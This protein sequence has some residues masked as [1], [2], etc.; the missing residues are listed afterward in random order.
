VVLA[1]VAA[2]VAADVHN[3]LNFLKKLHYLL[4]AEPGNR[5]CKS[6]FIYQKLSFLFSVNEII[7]NFKAAFRSADI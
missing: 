5:P 1:A 3:N 2:Q 7:T 6:F 4:L